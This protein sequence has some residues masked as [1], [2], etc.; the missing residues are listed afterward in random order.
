[1]LKEVLG[2]L[3]YLP[4][5]VLPERPA[6]VIDSSGCVVVDLSYFYAVGKGQDREAIAKFLVDSANA[7]LSQSK[8][9]P[10]STSSPVAPVGALKGSS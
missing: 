10:I 7:T 9:V 5:R 3:N 4:W 1:M 6:T 8:T 2:K